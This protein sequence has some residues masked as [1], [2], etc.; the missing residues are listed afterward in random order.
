M[1]YQNL[2]PGRCWGRIFVV[3]VEGDIILFSVYIWGARKSELNV[4][5]PST[6]NLEMTRRINATSNP[7]PQNTPVW[8]RGLGVP[9]RTVFELAQ[10][11]ASLRGGI[12]RTVPQLW[13]THNFLLEI[14]TLDD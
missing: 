9:E 4:Y 8:I 6:A 2:S 10:D 14:G 11:L 1:W 13:S 3:S 5:V 7:A 12:E